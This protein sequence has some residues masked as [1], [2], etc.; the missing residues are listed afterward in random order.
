MLLRFLLENK[1]VST[2]F[3][4][5]TT[6]LTEESSMNT[7][8]AVEPQ[9]TL[10]FRGQHYRDLGD[11]LKQNPSD[12]FVLCG[13]CGHE[14]VYHV[15]GDVEQCEYCGQPEFNVL[16]LYERAIDMGLIQEE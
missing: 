13:N 11:W 16:C 14:R 10:F 5:S 12:G 15:C 4:V 6:L 7:C 3:P 1:N 2:L 8:S 9:R